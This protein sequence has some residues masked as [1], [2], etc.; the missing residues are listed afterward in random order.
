MGS[1]GEEEKKKRAKGAGKKE[2]VHAEINEIRDLKLSVEE[3]GEE[4]SSW[5][6]E[7]PRHCVA[8]RRHVVSTGKENAL[9]GFSLYKCGKGWA[10]EDALFSLAPFHNLRIRREQRLAM[11]MAFQ[12][13]Q[14]A[15]EGAGAV[16][17]CFD[18]I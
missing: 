1:G 10:T 11:L 17:T 4:E 8:A 18:S 2:P 13:I 16:G 3:T 15:I 6:G 9:T 12:S 7:G 14:T 5:V